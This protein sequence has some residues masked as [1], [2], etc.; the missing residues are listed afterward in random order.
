MWKLNAIT[1]TM[2]F[3]NDQNDDGFCE[4]ALRMIMTLFRNYTIDDSEIDEVCLQD[5]KF[6]EK[7][8]IIPILMEEFA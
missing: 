1:E 4:N 5:L 8:V 3:S 7:E 6:D 2:N